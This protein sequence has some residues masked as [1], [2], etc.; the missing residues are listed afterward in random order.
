M[1]DLQQPVPSYSQ[2]FS[3][4]LTVNLRSRQQAK[5]NNT[6]PAENSV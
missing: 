3:S 1:D 4:V 2:G 5:Y 6:K